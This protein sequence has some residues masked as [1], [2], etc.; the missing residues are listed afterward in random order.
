MASSKILG[1]CI[2]KIS[3]KKYRTVPDSVELDFGGYEITAET[4]DDEIHFRAGPLQASMLK[5]E[6]LHKADTDIK[7]LNELDDKLVEVECKD[8]GLT[9][10]LPNASRTG[11]P[12]STSSSN[13][14]IKFQCQGKPVPGL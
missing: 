2:V 6:F 14:H 9:Y 5:C 12:I 8:L 11:P 4:A 7:A 13:G 1:V 10:S 3:G